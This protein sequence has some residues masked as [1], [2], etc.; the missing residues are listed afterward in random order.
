M[1]ESVK[2]KAL[3]TESARGL[4]NIG[5]PPMVIEELLPVGSI[6]LVS[7]QPYSGKTFFALE[8]ARAVATDAPFM[9]KWK[10]T[11]PGNVLIVEQDSPK[12]DTGRALWAM[13]AQGAAGEDPNE[14]SAVDN[15][16]ISW[17]PGLD[18]ASRL[19]AMRIIETA[20][21]MWSGGVAEYQR[22]DVDAEGNVTVSP[23]QYEYGYDGASLI[24]LDS[25]RSLH[26]GKEDKSDDMEVVLQNI[27]F[28]REKTGA[29]IILIAHDNATGEKTRG[30]TA[31]L[32]LIHI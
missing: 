6:T 4:R 24:I 32:S 29:A 1:S 20:N 31:I 11:R 8:A 7:G 23:E 13:L 18:L 27:K 17:H 3:T 2:V 5:P 9:G 30:S 14:P 16:R 25:S 15:I 28:I 19:D 10:V 21:H 26:R 22:V 12:Y